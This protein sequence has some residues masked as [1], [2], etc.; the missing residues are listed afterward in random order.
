MKSIS[1]SHKFHGL[2]LALGLLTGVGYAA[3][4]VAAD[5]SYFDELQRGRY[6][7]RVGDCQGCHTIPGNAPFTGGRAIVTPFGTL[8]SPNLTPDVETGI[9]GWSDAQFLQAVKHGIRR[10]GRK[11]YPA[12]PYSYYTKASDSDLLAIRAYLN[13]LQPVRNPVVSNQLAFPFSIRYVMTGWNMLFFTPGDFEPNPA[14]SEEWNRGAYLVDG[15]GHCGACHTPR[16]MLGG[17]KSA[18]LQGGETDGFTAPNITGDKRF[19]LGDWTED[20]IVTYLKTGRNYMTAAT[21]PMAE[22]VQFSTQY[23]TDGDLKAMAVYLKDMK[24]SGKSAPAPL[25]MTDA[26]MKAGEA[27]YLDNCSACHVSNGTGA[28]PIFPALKGNAIVQSEN[29]ATVRRILLHGTK[30]VATAKAPTAPA[31]P[32]FNWKLTDEQAASV[33]TYIRNAWGNAASP[34]SAGDVQK[35]REVLSIGG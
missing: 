7:T 9:G 10:N 15:L 11:I 25:P 18:Y 17:E 34:V 20:D 6:L 21:G 29:T 24:G 3:Q 26:V 35:T 28:M 27:V 19:G 22:V 31:M 16:N 23:M 33:I 13:S 12:L 2:V 14:K 30:P 1:L 5:D 4:A 32:A 8:L